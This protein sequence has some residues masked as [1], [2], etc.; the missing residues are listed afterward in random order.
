MEMHYCSKCQCHT[1][2]QDTGHCRTCG[3]MNASAWK[4]LPPVGSYPSSSSSS[5]GGST[6]S[7][8]GGLIVLF[9]I[10]V[11]IFVIV[12][13]WTIVKEWAR[14]V[15]HEWPIAT[16]C[17]LGATLLVWTFSALPQ[18][19]RLKIK[20][21]RKEG[22]LLGALIGVVLVLGVGTVRAVW[23]TPQMLIARLDNFIE[24]G[25]EEQLVKRGHAVIPE[26]LSAYYKADPKG[27]E[28]LRRIIV[29][30]DP[31]RAP[32]TPPP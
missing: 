19:S 5:G 17:L 25:A 31:S 9:V 4:P 13:L 11:V 1:Y 32:A 14:A 23:A 29:R 18:G 12:L 21:E 8:G 10:G 24:L 3:S 26:L 6:S 15:W 7:D 20:L 2:H 28:R 16:G 22:A 27:Q 30:I